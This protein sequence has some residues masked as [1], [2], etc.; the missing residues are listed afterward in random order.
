M[1]IAGLAAAGV[2]AAILSQMIKKHHPEIAMCV[3]IGAGAVIAIALLT[4]LV[5]AIAEVEALLNKTG[6]S[7]DYAKILFKALGICFLVQF[8]SDSCKDAGETALAGKIE[9]GGRIAMIAVSLPLF[10]A[11]LEI[12]VSL[13]G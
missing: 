9:F 4:Q 12:V 8:S 1:N 11:V 7:N 10:Q 5:P 13:L 6:L 3:S 2:V